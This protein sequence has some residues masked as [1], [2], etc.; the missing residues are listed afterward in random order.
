MT[1]YLAADHRGLK[2]KEVIKKMLAAR[3]DV[4]EDCGATTLDSH[5]DY[6]DFAIAAAEKIIQNTTENRGI[7]ICGSGHGMDIVANKF[8]GI[9]AALCWSAEV[10][11][12]S[13]EHD[14]ANVLVLPADW[15][16][17]KQ[18]EEMVKIWLETSFSNEE[19]HARRLHKIQKLVQ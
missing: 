19:R 8:K 6:V 4:F 7:F 9:R 12:Q 10:A 3:G 11:R 17:A 18:A 16:D 13:R 15:V 5:D 14:D 2:L 1:L